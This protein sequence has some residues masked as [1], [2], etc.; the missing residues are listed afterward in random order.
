MRG[1]QGAG[2]DFSLAPQDGVERTLYLDREGRL[3]YREGD[4][5]FLVS[6]IPKT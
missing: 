4:R 5:H 2:I 1:E 6:V 3:C